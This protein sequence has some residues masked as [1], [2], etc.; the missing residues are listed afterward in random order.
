MLSRHSSGDD[1]DSVMFYISGVQDTHYLRTWFS[2]SSVY[3]IHDSSETRG[4][5]KEK[6]Y[7]KEKKI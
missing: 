6:T 2:G 4:I 1:K 5:T 7:W 3:R